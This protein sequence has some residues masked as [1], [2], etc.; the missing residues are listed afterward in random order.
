MEMNFVHFFLFLSFQSWLKAGFQSL[1]CLGT[2]IWVFLGQDGIALQNAGL[3]S[4]LCLGTI[5]FEPWDK[6]AWLCKKQ[7]HAVTT[8]LRN[9][10]LRALG[11][12]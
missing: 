8:L 9:H 1:L 4:P 11:K 5:R 12:D 2:L 10:P 7:S 3:Q 6:T